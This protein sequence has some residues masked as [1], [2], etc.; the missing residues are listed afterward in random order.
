MC[1]RL[2]KNEA[3]PR[4]LL[5]RL[6]LGATVGARR[7][8]TQVHLGAAHRTTTQVPLGAAHSSRM[9]VVAAHGRPV[10]L[11]VMDNRSTA[12]LWLTLDAARKPIPRPP[13]SFNLQDALGWK[14]EKYKAV[15]VRAF[16]TPFSLHFL[17]T[18]TCT[19]TAL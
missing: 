2:A 12:M 9:A 14:T 11:Q 6:A 3:L 17:T 7:T 15:R 4:V 13:G 16:P 10:R 1:H 5:V 19:V 18:S 8:T